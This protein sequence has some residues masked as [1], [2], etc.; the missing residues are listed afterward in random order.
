[1]TAA[2][3]EMSTDR[4]TARPSDE[5]RHVFV[6]VKSTTHPVPGKER[7]TFVCDAEV[8][9]SDGPDEV[10]YTTELT[11]HHPRGWM[12]VDGGFAYNIDTTKY[13]TFEQ[14]AEYACNRAIAACASDQLISVALLGTGKPT[15]ENS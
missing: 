6:E 10:R 1:M 9:V 7:H 4:S 3:A 14:R 15:F 8:R 12:G 5:V 11:I 13:P 2:D